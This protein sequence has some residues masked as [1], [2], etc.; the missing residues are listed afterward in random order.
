M[1]PSIHGL[2]TSESCIVAVATVKW[3][4]ISFSASNVVAITLVK[5]GDYSILCLIEN[6]GMTLTAHINCN[7]YVLNSSHQTKIPPFRL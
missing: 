6:I 3:R 4:S 7:G 2:F 5:G 1:C